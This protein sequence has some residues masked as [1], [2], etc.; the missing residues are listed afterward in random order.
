MNVEILDR[1]FTEEFEKVLL[2]IIRDDCRQITIE[3][4]LR[5]KTWLSQFS[6]WLSYQMIRLLMRLLAQMTSKKGK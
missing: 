3:E 6:G 1:T 5:R 2:K 4:Y